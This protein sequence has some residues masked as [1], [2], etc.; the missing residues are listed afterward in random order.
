MEIYW[1]S[2]SFN[3][4][5]TQYSVVLSKLVEKQLLNLFTSLLASQ[6]KTVLSICKAVFDFFNGNSSEQS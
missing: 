5:G 3:L 4:S 6:K 2:P 1:G